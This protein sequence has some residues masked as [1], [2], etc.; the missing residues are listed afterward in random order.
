MRSRLVRIQLFAFIAVAV[1]GIV[2]VGGKYVR[3]DNLL[4][5]GQYDVNAQFADSGGIFTNAEVTYR[6]VPVGTVGALSLTSDGINVELLLD[7]GGPNIPSSAKAVVANRSAIGEQYVDLQPTSDE[8]PYLE[9]GSIIATA[10]TATPVPVE[11]VL[12]S[13]NQLVSSVPLENLTTVVKELGTAFN[14]KGDDLQ[15]LLDSL[16][17]LTQSGDEALPQT[18][19]LVRDSRTVLDTQSEQSSAIRQFSTDLNNV[20]AQLRSNDPDIRRLINT[21]TAASDQI[22]AL[23]DEGGPA[24]TTDLNNLNEVVTLAAP[25]TL[26]LQP[27]LIFLPALAAG[28]GTLTPGDGTIHQGLLLETNN[29]PPCTVG[30]EGTQAILAEEKAKNP[31][32]DMTEE[33]YPLNLQ[34]NCATPQGSVT[35]VRSSNRIVFADPETPQPWDSIPKVDPD[36]LNLNPIATQLA[37]LIGVTPK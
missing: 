3:I 19:A 6:G 24:L 9:S 32:F 33:N 17:T 34:A 7:N 20:T 13:A 18:L 36:K 23:I 2:Y 1:L 31:N 12:A 8:G 25:R 37:P 11:N 4:G 27:L 21:G 5:F 22:G 16:G 15:V 35:G 10:D 29:P 26:A 28:S 30:Y 14:G